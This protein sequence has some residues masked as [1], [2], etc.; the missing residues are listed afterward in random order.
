MKNMCTF[1]LDFNR[2]A[3]WRITKPKSIMPIRYIIS[4][5]LRYQIVYCQCQE[6]REEVSYCRQTL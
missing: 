5:F 1:A 2:C 6:Q 3:M 4:I